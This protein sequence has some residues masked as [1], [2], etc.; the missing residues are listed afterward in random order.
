[1]WR[2]IPK[3]QNN[4]NTVL[5]WI[6]SKQIQWYLS[7]ALHTQS[8]HA[9]LKKLCKS[10]A[11]LLSCVCVYVY[12]RARAITHPYLS[13]IIP[14]SN[15]HKLW[16]ATHRHMHSHARTERA[17]AGFL[18]PS[19]P[20]FS[21]STQMDGSVHT[22]HQPQTHLHCY[23]RAMLRLT[24]QITIVT[25]HT[26]RDNRGQWSSAANRWTDAG[27]NLG[28]G[29]GGTPSAPRSVFGARLIR[30][31]MVPTLSRRYSVFIWAASS[32]F[33]FV[34]HWAVTCAIEFC[35]H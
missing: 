26:L 20:I 25:G 11:S 14:D 27:M 9:A 17:P 16:H 4:N 30:R 32:G 29:R 6:F 24:N 18:S 28:R 31:P 15:A 35:P 10:S 3:K 33:I 8:N 23:V 12:V 21:S 19:S 34:C 13:V 7:A 22:F 1:M 5:A 2:N